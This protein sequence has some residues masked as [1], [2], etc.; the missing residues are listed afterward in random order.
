MEIT[1]LENASHS[2]KAWMP[3]G[4]DGHTHYASLLA[5]L[6]PALVILGIA[7]YLLYAIT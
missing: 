2:A 4:Y 1:A 3:E 7:T 5:A 6:V